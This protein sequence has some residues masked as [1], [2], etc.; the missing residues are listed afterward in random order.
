MHARKIYILADGG[1]GNRLAGTAAGLITAD[2]LGYQPVIC[3][4]TNN[5]CGCAFQDLFDPEMFE[6][7]NLGIKELFH[8][9][10][11]RVF[12]I[13]ENQTNARL[14]HA[15]S[16]G[17]SA[18][19]EALT[20]DQDVVFFTAKVP[21]YLPIEQVPSALAR[22][23]TKSN[24][25]AIIQDFC[26]QHNIDLQVQGL[27][28]RKTDCVKLE[29]DRW[30][31]HVRR[32]SGGRFFVCS[33]DKDTEQR[34]QEFSN[35]VVFPKTHYVEKLQQGPW[36]QEK[37]TDGDGRVFPNNVNRTRE[38]VIQ[39]WIDLQILSQTT[40]VGTTKSSF[41]LAARWLQD[42]RRGQDQSSV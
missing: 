35:V 31:E 18:E 36:R 32:H 39:A 7:N 17:I 1:L 13:H 16:H 28:L 10:T 15:F 38:S 24:L 22:L 41:S 12:M 30:Y 9:W 20:L 37:I 4:P 34:F 27:H 21:A 33:D 3:W 2:R 5:W 8:E 42:H 14:K 26:V 40:I 11:D 29:E 23:V 25:Q 6:H 19:R